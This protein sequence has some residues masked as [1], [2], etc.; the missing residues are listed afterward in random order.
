MNFTFDVGFS[1]VV[2]PGEGDDKYRIAVEYKGVPVDDPDLP[3]D[4]FDDDA[5]VGTLEY[6][7]TSYVEDCPLTAD[8]ED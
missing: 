1:V 3:V 6:I 8:Y 4:M 2:S 7:M 5:L